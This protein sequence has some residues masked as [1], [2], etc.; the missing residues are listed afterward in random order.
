MAMMA[1]PAHMFDSPMSSPLESVLG[2]AFSGGAYPFPDVSERPHASPLATQSSMES[3]SSKAEEDRTGHEKF[4]T[5]P[6]MPEEQAE[7]WNKTRAAKPSAQ[8][9]IPSR[10]GLRYG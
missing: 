9:M 3:T 2:S 4:Y 1:D 5:A 8:P 10:P 6:E 7:D